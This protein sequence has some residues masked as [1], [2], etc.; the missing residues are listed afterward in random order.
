M[1]Q[2]TNNIETN[3]ELLKSVGVPAD[4]AKSLS[5]RSFAS[6][7]L[8]IRKRL[9]KLHS[10]PSQNPPQKLNP[11]FG[12]HAAYINPDRYRQITKRVG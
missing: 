8:W 11:Q 5:T 4:L 10:N 9:K 1:P 12:E 2:A 3:R 6:L 7:P